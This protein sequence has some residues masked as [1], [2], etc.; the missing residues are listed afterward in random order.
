MDFMIKRTPDVT[1][2]ALQGS[3]SFSDHVGFRS[4]LEALAGPK[5]HRVVFNLSAL[6]FIDSSGLGMFLIAQE[7]ADKL[8]LKLSLHRPQSDV[9][10][11]MDLA[12]FDRVI[13]IAP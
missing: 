9:K 10:R 4:A 5:G 7:E 2:I 3:L 11:V 12:K 6:K 13:E 1:E 8:G